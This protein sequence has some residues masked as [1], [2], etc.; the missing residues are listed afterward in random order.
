[1]VWRKSFNKNIHVKTIQTFFH[2][3]Q[4]K[5]GDTPQ[6]LRCFREV[7]R[8]GSDGAVDRSVVCCNTFAIH[9]LNSLFIFWRKA[10]STDYF[11]HPTLYVYL[12]M[13]FNIYAQSL[14]T[15]PCPSS[16]KE[17][18]FLVSL[19]MVMINLKVFKWYFFHSIF[20]L[21]SF[22]SYNS[23]TRYRVSRPC[24]IT[25]NTHFWGHTV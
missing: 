15:F 22:V 19:L 6:K 4:I 5:H 3:I 17:R 25:K 2:T 8:G 14:S 13:Y 24:Q 18:Y 21:Q 1:M 23:P 20:P 16:S 7:G 11:V 9:L 12:Q 10:T